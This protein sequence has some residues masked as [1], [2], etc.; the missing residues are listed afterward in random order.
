MKRIIGLIFLIVLFV[1][2][3]NTPKVRAVGACNRT[4]SL[5]QSYSYAVNNYNGYGHNYNYQ[6]DQNVLIVGVPVANLGTPYYWSVGDDLREER[7][8]QKTAEILAKQKTNS[9]KEKAP[10]QQKPAPAKQVNIFG[11]PKASEDSP[12]DDG[13]QRVKFVDNETDKAVLGIFKES[14]IQCHQPGKVLKGIKLLT[15][16]GNLHH[17]DT[18]VKESKY[19]FRVLDSCFGGNVNAMPKGAAPL[20]N[21]KIELLRNWH[22][23]IMAY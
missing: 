14:C 23:E 22:R 2:L 9:G 21:D 15:E 7:I 16:E 12:E 6:Y 19:R 13:V 8:A 10:S 3:L 11:S 4:I 20:S 18:V 1:V 5:R 17:E